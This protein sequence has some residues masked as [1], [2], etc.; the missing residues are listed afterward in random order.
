MLIVFSPFFMADTKIIF[1][2][3][4]VVSLIYFRIKGI[5][6]AVNKMF[7]S[8][9]VSFWPLKCLL[10]RSIKCVRNIFRKTNISN[11]LIRTRTCEYTDQMN[12]SNEY[13]VLQFR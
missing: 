2:Y 7:S 11:P 3:N 6:V 13:T 5:L 8:R 4:F 10:G 9:L 1:R 12:T